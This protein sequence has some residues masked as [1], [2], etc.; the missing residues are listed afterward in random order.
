MLGAAKLVLE[1][2]KHP[3]ALKDAVASPAGTTIAGLAI[4]EAAGA[5]AA[6]IE[7]VSAA[8]ERS[9]QLSEGFTGGQ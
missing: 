5:R 1:T 8:A 3:A 2:G 6:F 4:L 7:A 9:H